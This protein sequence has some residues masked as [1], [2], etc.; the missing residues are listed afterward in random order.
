MAKYSQKL[1]SHTASGGKNSCSVVWWYGQQI[2]P[3]LL[4]DGS[5][6]SRLRLRWVL[7]FTILWALHE[8]HADI[9]DAP[10]MLWAGLKIPLQSFPVLPWTNHGSL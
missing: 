8:H 7:S 1:R 3:Y 6:V 5:R 9:T 2:L 4:P 10:M